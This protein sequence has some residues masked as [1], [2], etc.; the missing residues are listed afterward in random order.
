MKSSWVALFLVPALVLAVGPA[1]DDCDEP[2]LDA[3]DKWPD[4]CTLLKKVCVVDNTLVSFDPA[5]DVQTLPRIDG[6]LWNFPSGKS[7]SDSF[8][9][10]RA[11]YKP[12]LRR[13]AAAF[14]E[15]PPLRNP[16]FSKCTAP[17]VLM[18]DWHYNCGEF[19]AETLSM[20]HKATLVNGMGTDLTLVVGIPES[21]TLTTYHRVMLMPYTKYGI[22]TVAEIG[23][24]DRLGQP[25]DWSSEGK[26]VNCF[27][28]MAFC[29][30]QGG[31]SRH[32]TPLGV[33]GAHLVKE[34][35][36]GSSVKPGPKPAPLPVDPLG[37]GG[38]R[39]VPGFE[40]THAPPPPHHGNL[41]HSEQFTLRKA[42]RAWHAA[43]LEAAQQLAAEGEP[44]PPGPPRLRVLIEKRGGMTRN[45][46]NLPDLLRACEEAD[47]AGFVHGPFRGLVCRPYS[48][49]GAHARSSSAVDPEHFRSNIAAVRSAHVLMAFH[50]AGAI[51]SFFMH[52]H[53][54]GP[55]ALLELRPCKLGSKYSRWP[56]SYEPALHETAG[57]AV[58][59]FAYNVEDK[60]QCRQSD[61]MALVKNHTFSIHYVS[62]I[63]SAHARDQH[64]ELRTDQ[65][66][67][68][69][70]HV[71]TL[72]ADRI[73]FQAARANETLHA[74]AMSEKDGGLQ[75]G[76]LGLVDYKHYFADRKRAAKKA[77]REAKKKVATAAG[78][79]GADN[80]GGDEGDEEEE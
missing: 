8:R 68:V 70:R 36:L 66:L 63:P 75:F 40:E 9:G 73:A 6:T 50:G 45:I 59:V 47:K 46:K 65:F 57:D 76:P 52:Q 61:Y 49:S 14:L 51:N 64:L 80:E 55:S 37:F 2:L 26:H 31:R 62:E 23:T 74:Y 28:Q 56:D 13:A 22:T 44:E 20:V 72:M 48:F 38:W 25:A 19:F 32:G 71:A 21:L 77:R 27:E 16:V 33:V 4:P 39:R 41:G 42:A 29:K 53:D 79:A 1:L 30:W 54:A 12:F 11:A 17:L 3:P 10:T 60:A 34:L 69:L 7:N 35:T 18:G 15:P 67:E 5:L 78:V 43:E 24:M 58:R